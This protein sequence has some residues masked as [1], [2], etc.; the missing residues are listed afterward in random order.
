MLIALFFSTMTF[1]QL[2]GNKSIPGDYP[3]VASAIADLNSS[4]VGT[5]GVIFNVAA[6][7]TETFTTPADGN[8]T[9]LTGSV[10]SPII[11]QKSGTGNNPVITAAVGIGTL[12][13]IIAIGG[14]DYVTFNG[15]NLSEN[16]ANITAMTQMEFG[17]AILKS[18]A[19]DGSQNITI[20]NCMITLDNTFTSSKGIYS[21]NHTL[22]SSTQLVIASPA[23]ANS[24]I[25]IYNDTLSNCYT[26]IYLSG[27]NNTTS[28]YEVLF[29]QNNEI[30][31]EGANIITDVAGGTTA[32]GYGIYTIYQNNLKVANNRVTSTMG[33][34]QAA[35]GIYLAAARNGSYDL[36]SNY[37]SF[38]FS[39]TGSS[40]YLYAIY[41]EMGTSGTSNTANIYNN[42]VTNCTYPTVTSA[43]TRFM[44][45][46][47]PGVNV[48][49]YNNSI[50]NNTV[51]ASNVTATGQIMYLYVNK[52]STTAG[53]LSM[54]DNLVDGNTHIQSAPGSSTIYYIAGLG[55]GLNMDYYNNTVT[56][57]I[58]GTSGSTYGIYLYFENGTK[59]VYNNLV[60]NITGASG[61]TYGLYNTSSSSNT[62]ISKVYQNTIRDI[63]GNLA[64]TFLCGIYNTSG[65]NSPIY[66]YNNFISDLRA[67]LATRANAP[68]NSVNSFYI[69]G[70]NTVY[71][72]NNS[73]YIN[74]SSSGVNFGTSSIFMSTS[75]KV[76]VR[77]NILVNSSVPAGMGKT[78]GLYF[79]SPSL[80]NYQNT[81]NFNNI[82]SG[83]PGPNN[84]L[85]Y[86]GTNTEQALAGLKARLAPRDVQTVTEMPPF[87]NV[88]T[89]PFNLHLNTATP[90]Q[91]EAGGSIIGA[92]VP[93]TI[94]FDGN[95]RYPNSG[96]PVDG[97]FSPG[98]PDIGADEFG[99]LPIDLT[100]PAISYVP[101][102]DTNVAVIRTLNAIIIDG[103]GVPVSGSG[104]P[105]LYWRINMGPYQ[106]AQGVYISGNTYSFTFGNGT[107]SG[108]L[109]SYYIAAQDNAPVP[110]VGTYTYFGSSGFTANPPACT[111]PPSLPDDYYIIPEIQ[112]IF[113]IGVGKDYNTL[114][115]AATDINAKWIAGPLTLILD[116]AT[117]P[118]ESFPIVFKANL[119]SGSTNTLTIRPNTGNTA[120]I[121]GN[122]NQ[123]IL[124][125]QGID[126][127]ILDGSNNGSNSKNLT[128]QNTSSVSGATGIGVSNFGGTDPAT[129]FTIKN[130]IIQC[131]PVNSSI[132]S[133]IGI[134]FN[135]TGGGYSDFKIQ[136]NIIKGA[137][138]GITLAGTS[139]AIASN[140]EITNNTIGSDQASEYVTRTGISLQYT[141]NVLIRGNDIMGPAEGSLNTGQ[142]GIYIGTLATSTTIQRNKIHD[143]VRT[144]DDGWGV[145]GIWFASDATSVTEISNNQLYNIHSPGINPGVGQNITYGIFVRSGGNI[146]ILHN[147]IYLTGQMSS[148]YDASS[149]CIGF[150]Y[151]ATGNNNKIV[152]NILK[153][154]MTYIGAPSSYGKAYGIMVSTNPSTLFSQID[155]NDYFIDGTNGNIGE[156]YTNGTGIV[157]DY[158]TLADWQAATLQESHSHTLDPVFTS[159]TNLL[160]TNNAMN[161]LGLYLVAVPVDY[162]GSLRSNPPDIGALEFGNDP[163]VV[164]LTAN[165]ITINS[166]IVNG[167]TNPSGSS[168]NTFFDY[169]LDNSYGTSLSATPPSVSGSNSTPIQAALS[170]LSYGTTYHYRARVVKTNG[171]TAYGADSVFTT[172][173]LAPSVITTA[174]TDI[175]PYTA[176]LNGT[177]NPNGGI[178]TV[179]FQWGLTN[180]YG[181]SITA[182]PVSINGFGII[183]AS[184]VISGLTPYTV[185]H[186]RIVATNANSTSYGND[187]TFTTSPIA[188]TVI[189]N[190]ATD[191]LGF[192]ATLNGTINANYAPT[193]A[194]FEWGLSTAYGNTVTASPAVV[195]GAS[196]TPVSVIITDL[197]PATE[198]HFRCVGAGP[199]GT[200]YGQ[201]MMFLSD[202]PT[203]GTAGQISGQQDVC[204]YATGVVYSIEPVYLATGYNWTLPSGVTITSGNNT[205]IITVTFTGSAVSGNISV[206]AT[207]SCGIGNSSSLPVTVHQLPVATIAGSA[208]GC[209]GSFGNI[210]TTEPGMTDYIWTV[211]GGTITSGTGTNQVAITWNN[212]GTQTLTVTYSSIWGC[213]VAVPASLNVVVGNLAAPTIIGDN[214]NCI[215]STNAVYTTEQGFT[216]Y[217]WTITPGGQIV[218]GQGTYQVEVNWVGSGVQTIT[219]N[220]VE[221]NGCHPASPTSM[222]VEIRPVPAGPGA[223]TGT[224]ELCAGS[225]DVTYS[226]APVP[227][228]TNYTWNLP[229]GATIVDGEYTNTIKVNFS[230]DAASG[231]ISVFASNNC[232]AGP[233]SPNYSVTIN[234]IPATPVVTV[235][236]NNL[237]HSSAPEGNQWYFEG[238]M[239]TG[240]TGQEYQATEEGFYWTIVTL[241]GCSSNE[242]NH[243]QVVFTGLPDLNAGTFAI[244]PVPSNG[245]FTVSVVIP[246]E[247]TYSINVYN[248][249]GVNVYQ[250]N[251]FHVNGKAEQTIN[252]ENPSYGIY[253]VVL[254]GG[255]QTI[256]RKI[257]VSK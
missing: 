18:S 84:V 41:C 142:T 98:A 107:T 220:Y 3:S 165:S 144:S 206:Y 106:A 24:N 79:S 237:L 87:M 93:I 244:Y 131:T 45:I 200:I 247:E 32:A 168:V 158:P 82:Y 51:G 181:N 117:Y 112:G 217:L 36:Y 68:Y 146:Q 77:N 212:T 205:N 133:I 232:G 5:G 167:A 241:N 174:A 123:S 176:T 108:D 160:P 226:V 150:Y 207:N 231:N 191:I 92:P 27:F 89:R 119:G 145:S 224:S 141:N 208:E 9:T 159:P 187:M 223:I 132:V 239:I 177:V 74:A 109:V 228:A 59:N 211:T 14:C 139:A 240:A 118:S 65:T 19:T 148:Q 249:L 235:D 161:N 99:G 97:S 86:D 69:S 72:Y 194:T 52:T 55:S 209:Q 198:Y 199:G 21:N 257:L 125:L 201:D 178:T 256:I 233:L 143:F 175:T 173:P 62:G 154:S 75:A 234:P 43:N 230:A 12:D 238:D 110:N 153:N 215:N 180:A 48:N 122:F 63:E 219:V 90:T 80:T 222:N 78:N 172:L 17:Y 147:S 192:D 162:N 229:Y 39:G 214:M 210:Y 114:T 195:T 96:Y 130:C 56:N 58:A 157:V 216:N 7:Y 105:V 49:V 4:G 104:L 149:A 127:F 35:Y 60:S 202:C 25:K 28:P 196:P 15:I 83:V 91:C 171:F 236:E 193:N 42:T 33:G 70:G 203:P 155:Y 116:D 253:T 113:H 2:T 64:A 85:Y 135:T 164:T 66:Y 67:P 71:I 182:I 20:H 47:S 6:G 151:Q 103:S 115:A 30:G 44:Y 10:T 252:L 255:S 76:D 1:A 128:I 38:Q 111:V 137:F 16:V 184:G 138:D 100:P 227:N 188:S 221:E 197:I 190:L 120:L 136:N 121:S 37:V 251:D 169:G 57:N 189:T 248:S 126:Y 29:D 53:L 50:T 34:T 170:G 102:T 129:N 254:T 94:D 152:N 31:I 22:S 156:Q 179:T 185:Y 242:S 225:Q 246:N 101:L 46:T 40:A 54:H 23:G 124:E 88:S 250:M 73:S 95:P 26:G 134:R 8:I 166:A 11:F 61:S 218:S 204:V 13:A 245:K 186:F 163:F 213:D 183:P 81:S 243:M 140:I